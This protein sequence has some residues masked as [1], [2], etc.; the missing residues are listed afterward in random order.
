MKCTINFTF[1][2]PKKRNA[3][4]HKHVDSILLIKIDSEKFFTTKK[5]GWYTG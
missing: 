1:N 4:I 3:E 5:D 2:Y